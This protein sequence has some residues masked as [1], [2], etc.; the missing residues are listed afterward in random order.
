MLTPG[1]GSLHIQFFSLSDQDPLPS[2]LNGQKMWRFNSGETSPGVYQYLGWAHRYNPVLIPGP[3]NGSYEWQM[4]GLLTTPN[5][6]SKSSNVC[7][8]HILW[9]HRK[10]VLDRCNCFLL[11]DK[12]PILCGGYTDG[13]SRRCIRYDGNSDSWAYNSTNTTAFGKK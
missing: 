8:R 6:D 10:H 5:I 7:Q 9:S 13:D 2:C 4:F 11:L 1:S 12:H 3:G